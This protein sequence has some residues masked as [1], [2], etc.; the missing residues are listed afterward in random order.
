MLLTHWTSFWLQKYL[1]NLRFEKFN[2]EILF[3]RSLFFLISFTFTCIFFSRNL[4]NFRTAVVWIYHSSICKSRENADGTL[5][6]R[7]LLEKGFQIINVRWIYSSCIGFVFGKMIII[8]W[9]IDKRKPIPFWATQCINSRIMTTFH[10]QVEKEES[11]K[12]VA[13]KMA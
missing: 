6:L 5:K 10:H 4:F 8:V 1:C 12:K 2:V 11:K 7:M 9:P 3:W 13:K